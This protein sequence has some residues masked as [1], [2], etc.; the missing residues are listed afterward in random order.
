[1]KRV[2]V[3]GGGASGLMAAITAAR[4]GAA[5]TILESM[6]RAGKKLLL[7]GNGR[8]NLTHMDEH[9][10]ESCF[11]AEPAF[12]KAVMQQLSPEEVRCFFRELGLATIEKNGY[13]YPVTGQ[14]WSVLAV[15]TTELRRLKVKL[16]LSEKIVSIE[17]KEA[18]W[19]VHTASWC[20]EA[21]ALILACGSKAAPKTGSDGSGYELARIA[22]HRITPVFPALTPVIC[23][24]PFPASLAGVRC[25][26]AVSLYRVENSEKGGSC[27]GRESSRSQQEKQKY[28]L[29]RRETGELQWTSYGISGI[30]IFQISRFVSKTGQHTDRLYLE[31]DLLPDLTLE[32]LEKLLVELS[33]R[34]PQEK[35]SSLLAGLLPE[36]LIP[37][38]LQ[39]AGMSA[40]MT[41]SQFFS[42]NNEGQEKAGKKI[43]AG[44]DYEKKKI[45]TPLGN[46]T[47]AIK[48]FHINIKGTKSFETCQ[49]C[50]GGVDT[51]QIDG[52]T[53]QSKIHPGLYFAGELLDVDGLCGGYN[54]QWAWAS[55][56]VAGKYAAG[57]Q[58][59]T[60]II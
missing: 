34:L 49:V 24:E 42:S 6:E 7:T 8:C 38:I 26:A 2:I 44:S 52:L 41:G 36:K 20:Y 27:Y 4:N 60:D 19:Q 32:E 43:S 9:P 51:R 22:G 30:L 54:L 25:R 16:K 5:V 21:E 46:L 33:D 18:L 28:T 29:I 17:R 39:R 55:G 3:A 10:E 31:L 14:A 50:G 11:G 12:I 53:L 56:Y 59:G 47:A 40:K 37:V 23:R 1:M 57:M 48:H 58:G 45:T 35:V 15:L 13:V